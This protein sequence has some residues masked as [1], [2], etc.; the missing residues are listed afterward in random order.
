[1]YCCTAV[2]QS[3]PEWGL[4]KQSYLEAVLRGMRQ[5]KEQ[6]QQQQAGRHVPDIWYLLA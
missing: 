3:R 1:M 5:Y 6:Q 2:P 4:S